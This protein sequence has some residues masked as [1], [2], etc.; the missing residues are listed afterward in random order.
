M[1][2]FGKSN[3]WWPLEIL[4]LKGPYRKG[5][6]L[7][8]TILI[9]KLVVFPFYARDPLSQLDLF[10]G[11]FAFFLGVL[12]FGAIFSCV[13]KIAVLD[14]FRFHTYGMWFSSII[15]SYNHQ[16]QTFNQKNGT[17]CRDDS[18][19]ASFISIHAAVWAWCGHKAVF[20]THFYI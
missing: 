6:V 17:T 10:R 19:K 5:C 16:Y 2:Q 20:A 7:P 3:G 9:I 4:V 12:H 15:I 14:R 11:I 18:K 8:N 13:E 1:G